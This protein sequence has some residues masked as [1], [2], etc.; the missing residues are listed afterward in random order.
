MLRHMLKSKIHRAVITASCLDY[1]G[2]LTVD[3][4]LMA[5]ADLLEYEKIDVY[6]IYNGER[7]STY[8]IPGPAGSGSICLNGAAARKG[9]SGDLVIICSY[10]LIDDEAC[11]NYKAKNIFVDSKNKFQSIG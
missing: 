6:N 4:D 1:A 7:F 2:S 9:T 5:A 10:V 3:S 8:V 11:R